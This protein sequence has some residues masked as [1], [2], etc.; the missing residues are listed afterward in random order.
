MQRL[1][2]GVPNQYQRF[3][4][5]GIAIIITKWLDLGGGESHDD[6]KWMSRLDAGNELS[7]H[8][9]TWLY[10]KTK[11][12]VL[13]YIRNRYEGGGSDVEASGILGVP[14]RLLD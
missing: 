7:E 12:G 5:K 8:P 11:P 6:W 1:P 3:G 9:P 10:L 14:G 4:E 2:Y 13:G